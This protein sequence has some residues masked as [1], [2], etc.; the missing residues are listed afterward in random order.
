MEESVMSILS[1]LQRHLQD[2][3]IDFDCYKQMHRL[4]PSSMLSW[5]LSK[6]KSLQ[7]G[8]LFFPSNENLISF[9]ILRYQMECLHLYIFD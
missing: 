1:P 9:T 7:I 2:L 8:I 5:R 3:A 4:T 6:P